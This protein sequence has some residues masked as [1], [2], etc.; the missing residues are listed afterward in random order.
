MIVT[1]N[2][3]CLFLLKKINTK[4][5]WIWLYGLFDIVFLYRFDG[6]FAYKY[7]YIVYTESFIYL[8]IHLLTKRLNGN[9]LL[10]CL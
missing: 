1:Y 7:M 4:S 5:E 8:F 3:K 10:L 6:I 2:W 9:E